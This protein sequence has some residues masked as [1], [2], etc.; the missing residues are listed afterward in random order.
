MYHMYDTQGVA[1][2]LRMFHMGST[3]MMLNVFDMSNSPTMSHMSGACHMSN[4]SGTSNISRM[5]AMAW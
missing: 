2:G 4:T 5:S 3:S 1:G